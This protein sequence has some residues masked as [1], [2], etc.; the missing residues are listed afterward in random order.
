M[1]L[2]TG[3]VFV[4]VTPIENV[5]ARKQHAAERGEACL[6]HFGANEKCADETGKTK[7]RKHWDSPREWPQGE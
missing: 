3:R 5:C 2:L 7:A 6:K 4:R 1:R